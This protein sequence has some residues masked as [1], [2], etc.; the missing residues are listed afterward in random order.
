MCYKNTPVCKAKFFSLWLYID[1][2]N[3]GYIFVYTIPLKLS[4]LIKRSIVYKIFL[5]VHKTGSATSAAVIHV[6]CE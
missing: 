6:S 5:L 4:G 1:A 2:L 3:G